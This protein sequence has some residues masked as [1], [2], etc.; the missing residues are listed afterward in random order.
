MKKI[1]I[2]GAQG[3]DGFILSRILTKK[4]YSVFGFV[5]KS[6]SNKK[7]ISTHQIKNFIK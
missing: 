2:T 6:S 4:K 3:Q 5:K 7:S 1:I